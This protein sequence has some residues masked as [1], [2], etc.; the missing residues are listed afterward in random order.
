MSD[1]YSGDDDLASGEAPPTLLGAY[2]YLVLAEAAPD[3][4]Q[5]VAGKLLLA[6]LAPQRLVM[7][8]GADDTLQIEAELRGIAHGVADS[9]RG[10]LHRLTCVLEVTMRRERLAGARPAASYT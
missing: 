7:T 1:V 6:N 9:I 8:R 5:R 3:A 10:Q 2:T 4:L